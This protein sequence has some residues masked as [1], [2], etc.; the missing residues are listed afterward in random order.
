[1]TFNYCNRKM[2]QVVFGEPEDREKLYYNNKIEKVLRNS[3]PEVRKLIEKRQGK[4]P[5]KKEYRKE[6]LDLALKIIE[7]INPKVK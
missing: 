3:S 7:K 5:E 6:N 1:M 2:C 4:I